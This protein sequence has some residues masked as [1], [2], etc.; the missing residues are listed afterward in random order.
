MVAAGL[1]LAP[2]WYDRL[3]WAGVAIAAAVVVSRFSR[4]WIERLARRGEDGSRALTQLRRRETA[5]FVATTALR[6]A[7]FVAATFAVIGIFVRNTLAA[8]GGATFVLAV[9]AFGFQRLLFDLVAGFLVLFEGWYGV[10]D[11]ITLQPMNVSGFVEEFGLRT[12]VLRS[13]N[14]DR[15]YVPNGQINAA[16]RSPHGYR[17]YSVEVLT[18]NVPAVKAAIEAVAREQ[19]AGEARFLRPP[20][21]VEVRDVSEGVWLVRAQCDVPPTLEW[22]AESLL[23]V[24][25]R[26]DLPEEGMLLADPIV[27]TLDEAAL[28]R[29]ER[30][31]LVN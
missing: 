10:G 6:Y 22:L 27:Y 24:R 11:F 20:H 19:P 9:A 31:L 23:P 15:I 18:R 2:G 25:L 12:T 8:F 28:S 7:V 3:A 30:R 17:R 14:G 4:W 5:V 16:I 21:V 29:Y 1:H 13:L 26:A